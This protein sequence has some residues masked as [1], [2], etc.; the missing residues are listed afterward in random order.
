VVRIAFEY[1]ISAAIDITVTKDE[2]NN[3]VLSMQFKY[4]RFVLKLDDK[5][6]TEKLL[7]LLGGSVQKKEKPKE[8][9]KLP[10]FYKGGE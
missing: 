9:V 1:P 3:S 6:K 5:I 2:Q 7:E 8:E 10:K 4:V